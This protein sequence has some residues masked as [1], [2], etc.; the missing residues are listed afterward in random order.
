MLESWKKEWERKKKGK[1]TL[2]RN[3]QICHGP[4]EDSLKIS[5]W[6]KDTKDLTTTVMYNSELDLSAVI[7]TT[8][9]TVMD[10]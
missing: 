2:V 10:I 5:S 8:V 7:E 4:V 9:K 1:E 6:H 3:L